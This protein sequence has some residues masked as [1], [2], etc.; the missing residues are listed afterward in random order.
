M[1]MRDEIQSELAAAF[2]DADEL[3]DA[4]KPVEGT[5]KTTPVYDP[6]TGTSSGG[7]LSYTGRGIFGSYNAREI[8]GTLIQASDERLLILQSELHVAVDGQPTVEPAAPAVGDMI[9]GKRVQTVGQ[10]PAG[11]TWV[12]QL[13]K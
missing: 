5:R 4:V 7:T 8:D 13:R 2:D 12:L 9:T 1:G 6:A 11:A 3:A 10:D